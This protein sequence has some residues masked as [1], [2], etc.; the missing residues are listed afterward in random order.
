MCEPT[1]LIAAGAIASAAVSVYGYQQQKK[2][3]K[4]MAEQQQEQINDQATKRINDRMAEARAL[5][6]Q[7]RAAAA[8]AAVSGNSIDALFNDITAQAG[9]D[10]AT[11]ERNRKNG[12]AASEAE[13]GARM[14]G[15]TAE[16]LGGVVSAGYGWAVNTSQYK[17]NTDETG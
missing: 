15:A 17:I 8:E 5:R 1:T 2:A 4:Q 10:V 13:A 3:I 6:S 9:Q 14:R 16:A 12:I 11:M 7:A